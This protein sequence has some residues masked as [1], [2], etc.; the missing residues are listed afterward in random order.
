MTTTALPRTS[1]DDAF[2]CS[3]K[4]HVEGSNGIRVPMRQI[5]LADSPGGV[6]NQPLRV[7]DTS[8]PQ[9][10]D[11]L[12]GLPPLRA[13]WIAARAVTLTDRDQTLG[14]EMPG[15]LRRPV[16]RGTGPLTQMHFARRGEVTPEMEFVALREG[17][18]P[19]VVMSE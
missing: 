13:D 9:G 6:P 17:M 1:F 7:Y 16:L 3:D 4:V 12:E 15:G 19:S 11:V 14:L 10:V 5:T 8:G 2:P 18:D